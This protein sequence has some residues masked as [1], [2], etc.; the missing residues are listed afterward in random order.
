MAEFGHV[1]GDGI[2]RHS[3]QPPDRDGLDFSRA[4][5]TVLEDVGVTFRGS[6]G[7]PDRP[8]PARG[9]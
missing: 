8:D 2:D 4:P 1:G 6:G 9:V 3:P 5:P 7:G